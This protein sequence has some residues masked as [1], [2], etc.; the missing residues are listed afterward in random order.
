MKRSM[1][2]PGLINACKMF[3]FIFSEF[4]GCEDV[5]VCC[6]PSSTST[7]CAWIAGMAF[8]TLRDIYNQ[9]TATPR[10]CIWKTDL[11]YYRCESVCYCVRWVYK[12][13]SRTIGKKIARCSKAHCC[14]RWWCVAAAK[15]PITDKNNVITE[16]CTISNLWVHYILYTLL[17]MFSFQALKTCILFSIENYRGVVYNAMDVSAALTHQLS[18]I[19]TWIFV[20]V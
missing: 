11:L 3:T 8:P 17:I 2:L 9:T 10:R 13:A 14:V 7:L 16:T 12:T 1:S 19:S 6:I 15:T 5:Y 20:C 4:K 18:P